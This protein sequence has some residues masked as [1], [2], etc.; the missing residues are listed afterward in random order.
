MHLHGI[1]A[2]VCV[3]EK[4]LYNFEILGLKNVY[5]VILKPSLIWTHMCVCVIIFKCTHAYAR[6]YTLVYI[7]NNR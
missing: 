7:Y 6:G 5:V 2:S 1:H 3:R 4:P